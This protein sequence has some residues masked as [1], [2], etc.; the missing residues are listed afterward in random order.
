MHLQSLDLVTRFYPIE[1][2]EY[3][4]LG[5][6]LLVGAYKSGELVG[7][8]RQVRFA[9]YFKEVARYAELRKLDG[10]ASILQ[11]LLVNNLKFNSSA[12]AGV[13]K[14]GDTFLCAEI[15]DDELRWDVNEIAW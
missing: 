12:E 3:E 8:A 13:G 6:V 5:S 15:S 14:F 7:E 11:L 9:N 10:F 2:A 4:K 1:P